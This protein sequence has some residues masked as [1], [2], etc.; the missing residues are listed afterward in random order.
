MRSSRL[1]AKKRIFVMPITSSRR[2]LPD[3]MGR[4]PLDA[5]MGEAH[6][7]KNTSFAITAIA[8][9]FTIAF[10][11][12]SNVVAISPDMLR[13][14]AGMPQGADVGSFLPIKRIEPAWY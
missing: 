12:W 13:P 4:M 8:L 5:P 10:C 11:A 3:L 1:C 14:Q 6:M 9:V 2:R 7:R